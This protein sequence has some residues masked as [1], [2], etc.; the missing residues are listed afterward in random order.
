MQHTAPVP[1][2]A[3]VAVDPARAPRSRAFLV[4]GIVVAI[5]VLAAPS[6]GAAIVLR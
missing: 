4:A 6:S 1:P 3:L 5:S 2:T